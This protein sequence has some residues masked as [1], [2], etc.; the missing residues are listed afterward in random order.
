MVDRNQSE[1]EGRTQTIFLASKSDTLYAHTFASC[2]SV[3]RADRLLITGLGVAPDGPASA[4]YGGSVG[5]SV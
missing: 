1:L 5:V 4:S 3:R 2:G